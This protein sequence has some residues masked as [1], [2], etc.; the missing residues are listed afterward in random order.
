[1]IFN[2]NPNINTNANV[3][4]LCSKNYHS[5][6]STSSCFS[7]HSVNTNSLLKQSNSSHKKVRF[8]DEGLVT[9]Y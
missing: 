4:N 6:N 7:N 3:D 8:D 5:N 9:I 2:S 1:M